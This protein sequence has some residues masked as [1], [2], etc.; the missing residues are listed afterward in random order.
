MTD[1]IAAS[2]L[3]RVHLHSAEDEAAIEPPTLTQLVDAI[4]EK[5]AALVPGATVSATAER[6]D[7]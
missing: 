7:E 3:V 6:L 2:Y 5:V 1:T 4:T